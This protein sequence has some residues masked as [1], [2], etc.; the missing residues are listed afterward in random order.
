MRT[1]DGRWR[2]V[3]RQRGRRQ[4]VFKD[5]EQFESYAP[6]PEWRAF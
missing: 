5:A 4:E 1:I 2:R 3:R 6:V